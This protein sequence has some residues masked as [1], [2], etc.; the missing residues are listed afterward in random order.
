[1]D[2][3]VFSYLV[4]VVQQRV[5]GAENGTLQC[6]D[7]GKIMLVSYGGRSLFAYP[8]RVGQGVTV[9]FSVLFRDFCVCVGGCVPPLLS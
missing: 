7:W 2:A 5:I 6:C 8:E 4:V 1:M 3:I 9:L